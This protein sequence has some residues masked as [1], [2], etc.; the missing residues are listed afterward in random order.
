MKRLLFGILLSCSAGFLH[1]EDTDTQVA[2]RQR[3]LDLAGA[4]TNDGYKIRD[5]YWVGKLEAGKDT[6]IQVN[7]YVSDSY[8]FIAS[9]PS[10]AAKLDVTVFDEKGNEV[11][12]NP[13]S[14][15]GRAAAG[16]TPAASGPYY[17]RLRLTEGE[18]TE[19]CFLY[20]YK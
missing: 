6:F 7:L 16:I 14:E 13:F 15:S 18:P 4:F 19:V 12:D 1:A 20:C 3:V 10:A 17:V 11:P 2:A 8:W 9:A 5:G